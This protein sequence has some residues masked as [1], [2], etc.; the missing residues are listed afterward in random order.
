V[1]GQLSLAGDRSRDVSLNHRVEFRRRRKGSRRS[2][3][4]W[5]LA[6]LVPGLKEGGNDAAWARQVSRVPFAGNL[7]A[8]TA[9]R[10]AG[11]WEGQLIQ[12][13]LT[14]GGFVYGA[15]PV[16]SILCSWNPRDTPTPTRAHTYTTTEK[17]PAPAEWVYLGVRNR[18]FLSKEGSIWNREIPKDSWEG[19]AEQEARRSCGL[20]PQT[21]GCRDRPSLDRPPSS[22]MCPR[23]LLAG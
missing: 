19:V 10:T 16:L 15:Q 20:R 1:Q 3:Q 6:W 11:L 14:H 2:S 17:H 7:Q 22:A 5:S 8:A 4:G 21:G 12:S 23:N 13:R 9:R 18:N